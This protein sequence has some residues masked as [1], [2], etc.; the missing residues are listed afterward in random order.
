MPLFKTGSKKLVSNYRPISLLPLISKLIEKII[1]RRV[2]HYLNINNIL[3]PS[4][5]GFRPGLGT[6]DS[7]SK[8]LEY[9]Y[10]DINNNRT[11][12]AIY[13]DLKKAFDTIDHEILLIKL[14]S[15]GIGKKCLKLFENYL[16]NR[17]NVALQITVFP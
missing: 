1:H 17:D 10:T 9:I 12:L 4:Q 15:I 13:F 2:Y 5:C 3:T 14:K 7:L 16:T 11:T 8:L 6:N